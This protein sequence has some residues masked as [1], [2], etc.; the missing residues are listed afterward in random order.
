M[1]Q[2]TKIRI[3][4]A[5]QLCLNS[6]HGN[7]GKVK[8]ISENE[9]FFEFKDKKDTMDI[10]TAYDGSDIY[11]CFQGSQEKSDWMRNIDKEMIDLDDYSK[12]HEGFFEH[13]YKFREEISVKI[14]ELLRYDFEKIVICGHSLG[15]ALAVLCCSELMFKK[16]F[17]YHER[18]VCVTLGSPRVGNIHYETFFNSVFECYRLVYGSDAVTRIPKFTFWSWY[19]HVGKKIQLGKNGWIASFKDHLSKNYRDAFEQYLRVDLPIN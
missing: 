18:V 16:Y 4:N 7:H 6:Y 13:F 14:D 19:Y 5:T 11:L 17:E 10:G 8:K 3:F 15:G 1:A 2:K 12:V 9:E